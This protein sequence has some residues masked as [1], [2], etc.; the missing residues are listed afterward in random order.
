MEQVCEQSAAGRQIKYE[1]ANVRP[2]SPHNVITEPTFKMP[3]T[4]PRPKKEDLFEENDEQ[5]QYIYK[6]GA[7]LL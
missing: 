7:Y 1:P 3:V 6:K 5:I 4:T 2:F